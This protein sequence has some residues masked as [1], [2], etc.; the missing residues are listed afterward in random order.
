[1][2]IS[3]KNYETSFFHVMVQGHNKEFIFDKKTNK[4]KYIKLMKENEKELDILAYCVMGNHVHMLLCVPT[5]SSMSKF[6]HKINSEYAMYYNYINGKRIG[7]VYRDRYKSEAIYN[8]RYFYKCINYIHLN[9]VKANIVSKCENY[10]YSSYNEYINK[11]GCANKE[12]L[13]EMFETQNYMEELKKYN[14]NTNLFLD[15]EESNQ[16]DDAICDYLEIKNK[17]LVQILEDKLELENLIKY[18]KSTVKITYND[19]QNKF[20]ITRNKIAK[21]LKE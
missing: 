21:I 13:K 2:R 7:A 8:A 16:I 19:I 17:N 1:M 14:K 5:I 12:I 20:E 3:R 11:I 9:P 18:I 6:M 10:E 4:D 15:I